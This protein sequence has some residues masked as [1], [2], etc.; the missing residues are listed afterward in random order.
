MASGSLRSLSGLCGRTG[1][2]WMPPFS[3]GA[4]DA[5]APLATLGTLAISVAG[6]PPT[7]GSTDYLG[8]EWTSGV[9]S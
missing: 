6:V 2:D 5:S 8:I 9:L 1:P 7:F 3:R 4:D